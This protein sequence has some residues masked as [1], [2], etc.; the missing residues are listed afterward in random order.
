M[1]AY[2]LADLQFTDEVRYRE[3]Q[4]S[5]FDVFKASGGRL[6]CADERPR[7]LEGEWRTDKIVILEFPNEEVAMNFL[8]GEAYSKILRVRRAGANARAVL[9]QG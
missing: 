4:S 9:L 8:E 3:Y 2:V 1:P 5:F 7:T 6:L